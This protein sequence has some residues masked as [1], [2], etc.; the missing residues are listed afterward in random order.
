[1]RQTKTRV[2]ILMS[3][4]MLLGYMPWYSFSAVAKYLVQDFNLGAGQ[5]GVILSAFQV[6]YVL[7][8]VFTGWLADRVG[9]RRVVAWATVCAAVSSTLFIFLARDF[10]SIL[11]LRL[12]V[13]LSCGAMYAPGMAFL[14]AWFPPKE[15]GKA[16]G[17][18]SGSLVA[19]YAGGYLVAAPL[20]SAYG[21]RAGMLGTSIPVFFAALIVFFLVHDRPA[22]DDATSGTPAATGRTFEPSYYGGTRRTLLAAQLL[23]TLAYMGH[24]WELYAFW[25]WIGPYYM[26]NLFHAGFGEVQ[27]VSIG[28]M[29][30]ALVIFAGV[31]A[32]WA[33]GS[34]SDKIGRLKAIIIASL[35]SLVVQCMFGFLFGKPLELVV[36]VGLWLG[37]WVIADSGIYKA[38]LTE[39]VSADR[40]SLALGLQSAAGFSLTIVAPMVFGNL[41]EAANGIGVDPTKATDW[42]L[43]FLV[44]GLG[45]LLAP[46]AAL[47]LRRLPEAKLLARDRN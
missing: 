13:G 18:Y 39:L 30:S 34:L 22:D 33:I 15:R 12:A 24:M 20:A 14:S 45:A 21:W 10:A 29:L 19:A 31:P 44:L 16:I 28:G 25:G 27:T 26:A 36:L 7:I 9:P 46:L 41:L 43:P 5:M 1:M 40:R 42:R 4:A 6:G 23:I 17:A 47:A 11:V 37:F 32:V 38:G 3:I 2:L 35:C 8:V